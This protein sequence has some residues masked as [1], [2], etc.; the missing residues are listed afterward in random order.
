[1]LAVTNVKDVKR[2]QL[3][4]DTIF[5]LEAC[6][7]KGYKNYVLSNHIPELRDIIYQLGISDYFENYI[8][9]ALVGFDKPRPELFEYAKRLAGYPD[10]CYMVG[11][12]PEADILGG[13][14]ANMKTI[15]VHK[16]IQSMADYTVMELREILQFI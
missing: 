15:L 11:D 5:T 13:K 6:K 3:Y 9:S 2:Y 8:I 10:L 12:N 7:A 16:E 14:A 4:E 1:M